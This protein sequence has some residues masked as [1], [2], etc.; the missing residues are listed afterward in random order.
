MLIGPQVSKEPITPESRNLS[1]IRGVQ[2]I[3]RPTRESHLSGP[4]DPLLCIH[5][6]LVWMSK[7][8]VEE[9]TDQDITFYPHLLPV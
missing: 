8:P 1:C 2:K 4:I 7:L 5:L 9:G 6:E 3:G